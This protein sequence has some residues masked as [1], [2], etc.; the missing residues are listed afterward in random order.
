M[1]PRTEANWIEEGATLAD[2]YELYNESP[3]QRYPVFEG[4]PDNVK[5]IFSIRDILSEIAQGTIRR[6]SRITDLAK[7]A[8]FVPGSKTVG[9][10]FSEMRS[11]GYLMAVVVDEY[12]GSSG[13]VTI[14]QLI[15]EIVGEVKEGLVGAQ[16]PFKIV[17]EGAFKLNGSMRISE[18]N[19]E[20]G[21]ALPE[22]EYKTVGGFALSLFGHLPK[23]GEQ[24]VYN[25]LRMVAAQV[26]DNKISRLF[27]TR[28]KPEEDSD[29]HEVPAEEDED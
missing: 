12:G 16:K 23:E 4:S 19:Q 9:E 1:T 13:T 6:N 28:E 15:E 21:L 29:E 7:P 24:L 3:A 25:E 22:G 18:A 5:G 14:D 17:R 26:K 10:L 27:I 11:G 2:F 8:Y 20:L